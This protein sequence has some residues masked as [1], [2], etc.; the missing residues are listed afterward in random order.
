MLGGGQLGR[1]FIQE[2]INYNLDIAILDSDENAPCKN[3]VSN[4]Q[5]GDFNDFDTVIQFG[6]NLDILTI[7][8]EHV[9]VSAL[10]QLE[11]SGV[12]VFPQPAFLEM[13]QDKGLQKQFFKEN[14]IPTAPFHLIDSKSEIAQYSAEFPFFQKLRKG[15]YDGMTFQKSKMH[16]ILLRFWKNWFLL[17]AKL[18]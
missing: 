7:E 3:L 12:K 17:S 10:K 13:V 1:M 18:P 4:F 6:K 11:K 9:N 16:L 14:D 8:I 2:A 5:K 15:G